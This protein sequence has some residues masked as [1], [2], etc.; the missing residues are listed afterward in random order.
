VSDESGHKEVYVREFPGGQG[1]TLVSVRGGNAPRWSVKGDELFFVADDTL[2]AA[3]VGLGPRVSVGLPRPVFTA[4]KVGVDA[5]QGFGYDVAADGR[6]L[7]VVRI[8]S[9]P[10]RQ[11]VVIENWLAK[12][13]AGH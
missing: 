2:M 5:A 1:R 9:R 11:A 3:A 4:A 7:I 6:R 10:V 8:I 13:T 12:A